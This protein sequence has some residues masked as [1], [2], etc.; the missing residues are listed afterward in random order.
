MATMSTSC[1]VLLFS[2]RRELLLCHA[3]GSAHWDIPKGISEPG[4]SPRETAVRE[5]REETGLQLDP[6]GLLDLGRKAYR[7]GKDLHLFAAWSERIDLG[8]CACSS[9]FRDRHG[10]LLP[11]ADAFE[12]TPFERLPQRCAKS[13]TKVLTQQLSLQD[14]WRRLAPDS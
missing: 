3:T 6:T 7:P 8:G 1:G 12:W 10:R 9:Q 14:L 4:E 5:T 13:M 2:P 11:E